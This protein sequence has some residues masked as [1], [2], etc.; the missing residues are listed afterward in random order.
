MGDSDINNDYVINRHASLRGQYKK[1]IIVNTE[2]SET[3]RFAGSDTGGD[4]VFGATVSI[5]N[6]YAVVSAPGWDDASGCEGCGSEGAI[7]YYVKGSTWASRTETILTSSVKQNVMKIGTWEAASAY[8]NRYNALDVYNDTVVAGFSSW[9]DGSSDYPGATFVWDKTK[10]GETQNSVWREQLLTASN[11]GHYDYFGT[12][13]SAFGEY[14]AVGAPYEDTKNT[15]SGMVYIFQTASANVGWNE[16]AQLVPEYGSGAYDEYGALF[17]ACV[18]LT[19][20]K[21]VNGTGANIRL[22]VGS[23]GKDKAVLW[24][25]NEDDL[26]GWTQEAIISHPSGTTGVHFGAKVAL[27]ENTL[28][29]GAPLEDIGVTNNGSVSIFKSSSAGGWTFH[30]GINLGSNYAGRAGGMLGLALDINGDYLAISSPHYSGSESGEGISQGG[31]DG[32]VFLYKSGSLSWSK[33]AEYQ[34]HDHA[35]WVT[36]QI[37]TCV[38]LSDGNLLY[39]ARSAG[40]NASGSA[41]IKES[42]SYITYENVEPNFIKGI[43]GTFNL[44]GQ[45]G[46]QNY[47]S[48]LK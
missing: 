24:K 30:Q 36:P 10:W 4:D 46:T 9:Y 43:G 2:F 29:V 25:K 11:K 35:S 41:T 28:I 6:K 17:G 23:Y 16:K 22:L 39:G 34:P 32:R 26:Y 48:S 5:H 45:T 18:Y 13:V 19:G 40:S 7:Y 3:R 38:S 37:G 20:S 31:Y 27:Y 14:I 42:L 21:P 33:I 44:R 8:A 47:K 15:S 1:E 12:G